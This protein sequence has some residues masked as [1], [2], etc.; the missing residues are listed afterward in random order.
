MKTS[1]N[2]ASRA[3]FRTP[4]CGI[5]K[6]A[7]ETGKKYWR[8]MVWAGLLLALTVGLLPAPAVAGT[9]PLADLEQRSIALLILD[10]SEFGVGFVVATTPTRSYLLTAAH[11]LGCGDTQAVGCRDSVKVRFPGQL[12]SLDGH[13]VLAWKDHSDGDRDLALVEVPRGNLTPVPIL[14]QTRLGADF[15]VIG[16]DQHII[17]SS[18]EFGGAPL[19]HQGSVSRIQSSDLQKH[20]NVWVPA[21]PGFSGGPI[22]DKT[23]NAVVGVFTGHLHATDPADIDY[24]GDGPALV[25]AFLTAARAKT[26]VDFTELSPE[27]VAAQSVAGNSDSA[28]AAIPAIPPPA[29]QRPVATPPM[30]ALPTQPA[31]IAALPAQTLPKPT[32]PMQEVRPADVPALIAAAEKGDSRAQYALSK[33][34]LQ[35]GAAPVDVKAGM[36]YC[37]KAVDGGYAA[38]ETALGLFYA[39]G[40]YVAQD[41]ARALALLKSAAAA[42]EPL[43]QLNLGNIYHFGKLDTKP[44]ETV[45]KDWYSKAYAAL[46]ALSQSGDPDA[47]WRL[48]NLY[49]SG[50]GLPNPDVKQGVAFLQRAS[51]LGVAKASYN[52]AVI[53]LGG[54][55]VEAN[56]PKGLE[57]LRLAERQGDADATANLADILL[58]GRY[59]QPRDPAQGARYLQEAAERGNAWA[60]WRL[61]DEY[62][63]GTLVEKNLTAA[64]EWLRKASD[65]GNLLGETDYGLWLLQYAPPQARNIPQG[66]ATLQDAA[67]NKHFVKAARVLGEFYRD[68]NFLPRDPLQAFRYFQAASGFGGGP[69]TYFDL[70]RS[71]EL[72]QGTAA[73][74]IQAKYWYSRSANLKYQPAIAK[75]AELASSQKA[76]SN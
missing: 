9:D 73:D 22:I 32:T 46:A 48:G 40:R 16:Y 38:A 28:L 54:Q 8:S 43:A 53:D 7:R 58:R 37:Y 62:I 12:S 51:D 67:D 1:S 56:V 64:G 24:Y 23:T 14:S 49:L 35:G 34:Y 11:V 39:D 18:D 2:V 69:V 52:L 36:N 26:A 29:A 21:F 19:V 72:G 65:Q 59:G 75:L 25:L 71:Y 41:S 31:P 17:L 68:G 15:Y 4:R 60:M 44:D 45:S 76:V 57:Y 27:E 70:A 42:G 10:N 6:I 3:G 55:T 63:M 47:T 61:G 5:A 20:L 50:T 13:R 66:L 30:N 33:V 74:P